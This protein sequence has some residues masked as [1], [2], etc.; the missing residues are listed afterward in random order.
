MPTRAGERTCLKRAAGTGVLGFVN[1]ANAA[2][3]EQ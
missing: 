1:V 3:V 2:F